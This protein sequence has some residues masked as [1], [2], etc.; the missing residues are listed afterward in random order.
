MICAATAETIAGFDA[1]GVTVWTY[2]CVTSTSPRSQTAVSAS[3]VTIVAAIRST[4]TRLPPPDSFAHGYIVPP[5]GGPRRQV[6]AIVVL[7]STV[8]P[9]FAKSRRS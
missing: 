5:R 7:A 6:A 2:R 4:A 1:S 8:K 3:G 9:L